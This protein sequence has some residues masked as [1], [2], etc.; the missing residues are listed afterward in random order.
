MGI[1]RRGFLERSTIAVAALATTGLQTIASAADD[2]TP[3]AKQP[4]VI[5]RLTLDDA[6]FLVGSVFTVYAPSGTQH[7]VCVKVNA[8]DPASTAPDRSFAMRFR[9]QH[10]TSLKQGTYSFEHRVLGRF[11]LFIVPSGPDA[12][13]RHYTAII[14]HATS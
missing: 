9:P 10:T 6:Q 1:S 2:T 14:N 5:A 11:R 13:H 4:D 7:F 12:P 3:N 8:T